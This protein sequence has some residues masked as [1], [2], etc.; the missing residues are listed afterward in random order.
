MLYQN[1]HFHFPHPTDLALFSSRVKKEMLDSIRIMSFDVGDFDSGF[2]IEATD[3]VSEGTSTVSSGLKG[4]KELRVFVKKR[5][6]EVRTQEATFPGGPPNTASIGGLLLGYNI[7][8]REGFNVFQVVV[9]GQQ[10]RVWE[11][12]LCDKRGVD[13]SVYRDDS[14]PPE[15]DER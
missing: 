9:P 6:T 8:E 15:I 4:L 10:Y 13:L 12:L 5:I 1:V 7:K 14:V 11:G 3:E 2:A